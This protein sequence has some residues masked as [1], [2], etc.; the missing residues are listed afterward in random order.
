MPNICGK[1]YCFVYISPALRIRN[2]REA[3]MMLFDHFLGTN[4]VVDIASAEETKLTETLFNGENKGF[5][6]EIYVRINT[7]KHSVLNVFKD[8]G[9]YGIDD[10]SR[11]HHLLKGI[12][13]TELDVCKMQVTASPSLLDDFAAT[14]EIY[15]TFIK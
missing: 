4:N 8:Y 10:S 1:H 5:T 13:I 15:S 7:E 2:G 3:Y 6:W 9:Y 12:K 14:M 11:V